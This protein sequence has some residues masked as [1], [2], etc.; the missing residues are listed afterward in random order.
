MKEL[1]DGTKVRAILWYLAL[2]YKDTLLQEGKVVTPIHEMNAQ[3][4]S[5]FCQT[6]MHSFIAEVSSP[7]TD[8]EPDN[9]K[10]LAS[11]CGGL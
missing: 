8:V 9:P 6:A 11:L 4:F 2:E 5:S 3:E 1:R 7:L 10:D